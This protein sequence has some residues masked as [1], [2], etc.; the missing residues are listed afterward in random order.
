[1]KWN[2]ITFWESEWIAEKK[3][4]LYEVRQKNIDQAEWWNRRA[5]GFNARHGEKRKGGSCGNILEMI[6]RSGFVDPKTWMLDIGCGPGNYAIPLA[7]RFEKVVAL[8]TSPE[9][10]SILETRARDMGIR[11]IETVC[12]PWEDVDLDGMNWR[13]RFGL[14]AAIKSPG[15]RDV[16]TL[17]KMIDASMSGCF[18]S[19]FVL[20]EDYAQADIWQLTFREKMPPVSADAFYVYHLVHAM[21][22]L[23][24]IELRRYRSGSLDD[25]ETAKEN[26]ALMMA[27]YEDPSG[28]MAERISEYVMEKST[29]GRFEKIVRSEE[30]SVLW[31]VNQ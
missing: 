26:L 17:R 24:S 10:L 2:T 4:S 5:P 11:N 28:M 22:Y 30:G 25:I 23:P 13:G 9:M 18:Y 21:G 15:I 6:H 27:P 19:G 31:S 16:E 12:M 7:A 14:V 20:R 29:D 3:R 1:M 8:D